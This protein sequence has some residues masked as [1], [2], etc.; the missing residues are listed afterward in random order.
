M[1]SRTTYS[2]TL[3]KLTLSLSNANCHSDGCHYAASKY[4]EN[5]PTNVELTKCQVDKV[6]FTWNSEVVKARA[7]FVAI[8]F[9][10]RNI[11]ADGVGLIGAGLPSRS[12]TF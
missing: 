4:S 8:L 9:H 1:F 10:R 2:R 12:H 3:Y 7:S 5:M 6:R 11:Q